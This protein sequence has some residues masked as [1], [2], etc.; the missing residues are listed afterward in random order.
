MSIDLK[1]HGDLRYFRDPIHGNIVVKKNGM[2]NRLIDS[3]EFQRLRRIK[4]LGLSDIAFHGATH[5]RF[6]HSIG[7]YWIFRRIVEHLRISRVYSWD[8]EED[9]SLGEI[10]SLL[11]DIGHPPLSHSLEG[12]LG[13]HESWTYR[14]IEDNKRENDGHETVGEIIRDHGF[15]P[16]K[17]VEVLRGESRVKFI[18]NLISSQ[19]D[20]DR[21]DY[22]L[23]DSHYTGV[24]YGKFDLNRVINS[25][26]LSEMPN[27][28]FDILVL[29][30]GM[31]AVEGFIISRYLMYTQ[32]YFHHTVRGAMCLLEGIVKRAIDLYKDG[33][34]IEIHSDPLRKVIDG[35]ELKVEDYLNMDDYTIIGHVLMWKDSKDEILR[36]LCDRFLNRRLFKSLEFSEYS[37]SYQKFLESKDAIVKIVSRETGHDPEDVERYYLM[38]DMSRDVPYKP[39][40]YGEAEEGAEPIYVLMQN[41]KI[42]RIQDVSDI[43]RALVGKERVKVRI[44]L[45]DDMCR[46]EVRNFLS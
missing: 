15:D 36:T 19:L 32:V 27:G 31:N 46:K 14:I 39:Y 40:F 29:E 5:N 23:R 35:E 7:V 13:E 4:Q 45:P 28:E 26:T 24:E 30:K 9:I 41:S 42:A 21:M 10:A 38:V 6:G 34:D 44:Y 11:H 8:I 18:S 43:I 22:L 12:L 25:L 33:K 20:S 2:I 1:P 17:V 16:D 37:L 3:P